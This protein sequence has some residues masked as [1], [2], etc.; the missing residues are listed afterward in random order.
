MV[1]TAE[2]NDLHVKIFVVPVDIVMMDEG[3]NRSGFAGG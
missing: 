1:R 2:I 3:V